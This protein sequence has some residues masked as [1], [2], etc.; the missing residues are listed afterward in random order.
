MDGQTQGH[1]RLGAGTTASSQPLF[2]IYAER[3]LLSGPG[4]SSLGQ[5]GRPLERRV[6]AWAA[7]C[8]GTLAL[9]PHTKRLAACA[10]SALRSMM[11]G[12]LPSEG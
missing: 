2:G 9:L 8:P 3:A 10:T 1:R 6:A 11:H 5:A 7:A 4:C 12:D